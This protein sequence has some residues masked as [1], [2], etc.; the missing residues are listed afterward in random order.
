MLSKQDSEATTRAHL[1]ASAEVK[2]TTAEVCSSEIT[3]AAEV[4]ANAIAAGGKVLR[5]GNGGSAADCQHMAAEL[6]SRLTS[7][8]VRP[9][10]PAIAL[11]TD[12]SFLTAYANDIDF[13]GVCPAGRYAWKAWRRVDWHQYKWTIAKCAPSDRTCAASRAKNRCADGNGRKHRRPGRR[14]G[15]S[16]ERPDPA[17]SG[18]PLGHRAC[19]LPSRRATPL[20]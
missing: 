6:V 11:T 9:G 20:R 18:D 16:P 15:A 19:H 10:M 7:D 13:D 12:T 17:H 5:C 4:I 2:C 1:R 8:F 14:V 3:R